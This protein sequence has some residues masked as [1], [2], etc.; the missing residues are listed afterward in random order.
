V[1]WSRTHLPRLA[2]TAKNLPEASVEDQMQ[3]IGNI[4]GEKPP[5]FFDTGVVSVCGYAAEAWGAQTTVQQQNLFVLDIARESGLLHSDGK[6]IE[7]TQ[8]LKKIVGGLIAQSERVSQGGRAPASFWI[9]ADGLKEADILALSESLGIPRA[10]IA[11]V[12]GRADDALGKINQKAKSTNASVLL[13]TSRQDT[14]IWAQLANSA[15]VMILNQFLQTGDITFKGKIAQTLYEELGLEGH[16]AVRY[17]G[18]EL[19]IEGRKDTVLSAEMDAAMKTAAI[20]AV[21]Q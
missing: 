16:R 14:S 2:P 21:Q 19:I 18:Q 6:T 3:D 4:V 9:V 10:Q 20:L 17:D 12:D 7:I 11:G 13:V 1:V 8:G 5:S 15:G